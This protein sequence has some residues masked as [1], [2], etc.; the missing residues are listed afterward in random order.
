MDAAISGGVGVLC[1]MV[2]NVVTEP[3]DRLAVVHHH[4]SIDP[5]VSPGG[6]RKMT[7]SVG[8]AQRMVAMQGAF[9]FIP[10]HRRLFA[11]STL[12]GDGVKFAVQD[13]VVNNVLPHRFRASERNLH[14]LS[15]FFGGFLG[16]IAAKAMSFPFSPANPHPLDQLTMQRYLRGLRFATFSEGVYGGFYFGLFELFKVA[17]PYRM[18]VR[19]RQVVQEVPLVVVDLMIATVSTFLARLLSQP[20]F[21]AG[22][23]L[24]YSNPVHH[25]GIH[26]TYTS[27]YQCVRL[28]RREQGINF[29]LRGLPTSPVL[30]A[31]MMIVG[32]DFIRARLHGEYLSSYAADDELSL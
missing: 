12:L 20:L 24:R 31:A 7:N 29:L 15:H 28:V 25:T 5:R 2:V 9:A 16:G 10:D 8:T 30:L 17:N 22:D 6:I 14:F 11:R 19:R 18:T 21:V 1:S 32:V 3:F 26:R 27:Y 4:Q 23:I 13:T